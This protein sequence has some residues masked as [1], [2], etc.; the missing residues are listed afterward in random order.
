M[1]EAELRGRIQM[2]CDAGTDPILSS[3]DLEVLVSLSRRL[4]KYG[5]QP[6]DTSWEETYDWNYAVA[7]GWLVKAGRLADHYLF[8]TGGKMLS[9]NQF[10]EHCM[11]LHKKY[12]SRANLAALRLVADQ[13]IALSQVESNVGDW[14]F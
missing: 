1:T 11:E 12:M 6:G 3:A 13:S 8:M 10:Y 14:T 9:R 7:Q 4:D 5:V 2:F